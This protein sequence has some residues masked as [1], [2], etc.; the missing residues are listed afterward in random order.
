[1]CIT[2]GSSVKAAYPAQLSLLQIMHERQRRR[3]AGCAA[4]RGCIQHTQLGA[5][6]VLRAV[7]CGQRLPSTRGHGQPSSSPWPASSSPWQG[8]EAS[9]RG[10]GVAFLDPSGEVCHRLFPAPS[11]LWSAAKGP[12]VSLLLFSLPRGWGGGCGL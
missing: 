1:M 7:L 4:P 9:R 3:A 12:T 2:F 11:P 10:S 8:L 6:P 5:G